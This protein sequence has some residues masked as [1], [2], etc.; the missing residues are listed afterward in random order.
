MRETRETRVRLELN[1]D[2]TGKARVKTGVGFFDHMLDA[3]CRF[4]RID[5]ELTCAGDLDV[6]AHHT[7]E[8]TGICIGTAIRDALGDRMGIRRVAHSY[9]PMDESLAFAALDMSNRSMFVLD[10]PLP[11]IMIGGMSAQLAEEFFRAVCA[12]AGL[13]LHMRV[14]GRNAHHMIEALFKAF[15]RALDDAKEIDPRVAGEIPS[16]KGTL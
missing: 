3:M 14:D 7:V 15:G 10:S 6:D 2:G 1:L 16:T 11:D 9:V 13:T 8:D 4:G 5:L 12:S